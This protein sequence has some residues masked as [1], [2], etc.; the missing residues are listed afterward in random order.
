MLQ[1]HNFSGAKR[2]S[3]QELEF[4]NTLFP[5]IGN[6]KDPHTS[7][8]ETYLRVSVLHLIKSLLYNLTKLQI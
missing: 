2:Q 6:T 5:L 3:L 4:K 1:K 7:A 8:S